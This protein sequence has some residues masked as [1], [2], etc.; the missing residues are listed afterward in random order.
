VAGAGL[1]PAVEAWIPFFTIQRSISTAVAEYGDL[2]GTTPYR[3]SAAVQFVPHPQ[4]AI[5]RPEVHPCTAGFT[6]Y[7]AGDFTV[8]VDILPVLGQPAAEG[9][10]YPLIQDRSI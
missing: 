7:F 9:A 4:C 3:L 5:H 6:N 8:K 2:R 10:H 1:I